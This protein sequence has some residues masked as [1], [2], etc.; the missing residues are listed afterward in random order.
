LK[1]TATVTAAITTV[2]GSAIVTTTATTVVVVVVVPTVATAVTTATVSAVSTVFRHCWVV[3][4]QRQQ[5]GEGGNLK[6][7]RICEWQINGRKK[8]MKG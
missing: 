6:N 3:L 1:T 2:V 5:G 8:K 7:K 4:G